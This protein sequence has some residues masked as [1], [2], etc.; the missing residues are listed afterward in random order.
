MVVAMQACRFQ[1]AKWMAGTSI[2]KPETTRIRERW[3]E[4]RSSCSARWSLAPHSRGPRSRRASARRLDRRRMDLIHRGV[5]TTASHPAFRWFCTEWS[6]KD[7]PPL[8]SRSRSSLGIA[9]LLPARPWQSLSLNVIRQNEP[10]A[11]CWGREG[12]GVSDSAVVDV[13]LVGVRR[14]RLQSLR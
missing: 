9:A 5:R 4:I 2:S 12:N 11:R 14:R 1:T 8:A 7:Y 13:I 10:P 6:G 3:R